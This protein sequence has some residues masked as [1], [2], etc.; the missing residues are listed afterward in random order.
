MRGG[1]FLLLWLCSLGA[2]AAADVLR[3]K[4]LQRCGDLLGEGG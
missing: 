4:Q 3:I 1:L 2:E